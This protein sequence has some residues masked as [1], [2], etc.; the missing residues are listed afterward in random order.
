MTK[1]IYRN[2]IRGASTVPQKIASI[3]DIF[4][5]KEMKHRPIHVCILGGSRIFHCFLRGKKN[6]I[7]FLNFCP[8]GQ[9]EQSCGWSPDLYTKYIHQSPHCSRYPRNVGIKFLG[10]PR[11]K[12]KKS[13]LFGSWFDHFS[14]QNFFFKKNNNFYLIITAGLR[15]SLVKVKIVPRKNVSLYFFLGEW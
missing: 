7:F 12:K 13:P 10:L 8:R 9:V 14:S 15:K 11:A 1:N 4:G 5:W 6:S 2:Q 3:N